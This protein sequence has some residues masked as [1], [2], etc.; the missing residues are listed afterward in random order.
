MEM[1]TSKD[2]NIT[3][4]ASGEAKWV[5]YISGYPKPD[6]FSWKNQKGVE[7]IDFNGYR[8]HK[9]E[10]PDHIILTIPGVTM[11]DGGKYKFIAENR[12]VEK[13]ID[14]FLTVRGRNSECKLLL[15]GIIYELI[16]LLSLYL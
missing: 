16:I 9:E 6:H 13:S 15:I 5:I 14:L 3:V 2:G 1:N 8:Y 7:L 10:K 12:F 11:Q 4:N